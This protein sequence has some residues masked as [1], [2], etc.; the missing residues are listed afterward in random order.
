MH[1]CSLIRAHFSTQVYRTSPFFQVVF[2]KK[3]RLCHYSRP[4]RLGLRYLLGRLLFVA[5][6]KGISAR[7][8]RSLASLAPRSLAFASSRRAC[9]LSLRRLACMFP[10][11]PV[12]ALCWRG[13][14]WTIRNGGMFW[15]FVGRLCNLSFQ[16]SSCHLL[17]GRRKSVDLQSLL[18]LPP[19]Q[20]TN[21]PFM[22][23]C[24]TATILTEAVWI[25]VGPL[26]VYG[27]S[28][29]RASGPQASAARHADA[30]S[31]RRALSH[32]SAG[33]MDFQRVME[34]AR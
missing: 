4:L 8:A 1:R 16:L 6:G 13:S 15:G 9:S 20:V 5:V 32:S 31:H 11:T 3:G 14:P 26:V 18:P 17:I 34:M 7:F 10:P 25:W 23:L 33:G 28:S 27:Q 12:F 29:G 30:L 19:Y 2:L 22:P 21:P 24:P